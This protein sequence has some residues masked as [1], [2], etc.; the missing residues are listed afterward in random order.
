MSGRQIEI[1]GCCHNFESLVHIRQDEIQQI[2][3]IVVF[4][5][6][7][8]KLQKPT[9][10]M[11]LDI[12]HVCTRKSA[13]RSTRPW[14]QALCDEKS[15]LETGPRDKSAL[16]ENSL[17]EAFKY[18]SY[19]Y[20]S[21]GFKTAILKMGPKV[22]T[23]TLHR[24]TDVIS[25]TLLRRPLAALNLHFSCIQLFS[26][27][28]SYTLILRTYISRSLQQAIDH[29]CPTFRRPSQGRHY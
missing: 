23:P 28:K 4:S 7:R 20:L 25:T 17:Q 13:L 14:V 5:A 6:S 22:E 16:G 18:A 15:Y 9:P 29:A 24:E 26:D 19:V 10:I 27:S 8:S 11:W 21:P 1:W 12:Q 2:C 3:L